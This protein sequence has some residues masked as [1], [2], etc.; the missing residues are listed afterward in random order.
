MVALIKQLFVHFCV[1]A[2]NLVDSS[3]KI[4]FSE[5]IFLIPLDLHCVRSLNKVKHKTEIITV[6]IKV[7]RLSNIYITDAKNKWPTMLHT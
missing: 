2:G 7:I 6:S 4:Q 1:E 3:C 5:K